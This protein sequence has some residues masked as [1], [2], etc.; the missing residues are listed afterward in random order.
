ML[1]NEN[2]DVSEVV[3]KRFSI[4]MPFHN[5][6]SYLADSI[7]SIVNQKLDF[8]E[9]VQLI[10]V[11]CGSDDESSAIAGEYERQYPENIFLITL[12]SQRI[13]EGNNAGFKYAKGDYVTFMGGS[14]K[15]HEDS[16]TQI[17]AA[18]KKYNEDIIA[19]PVSVFSNENHT[20]RLYS[21]KGIIDL[22]EF[23]EKN[24]KFTYSVF[25]RK[26]LVDDL[27][28]DSRIV[29]SYDLSYI[30]KALLK[31][32]K[33]VLLDTNAYYF[34]KKRNS[35]DQEL[36]NYAEFYLSEIRYFLLEMMEYATERYGKVEDFAKMQVLKKFAF[37]YKNNQFNEV[38]SKEQIEEFFDS[39]KK[40]LS[41][42][43]ND[44]I[45]ELIDDQSNSSFVIAVKNGDITPDN[46]IN[47]DRSDIFNVEITKNNVCVYSKDDIIDNV[48]ERAIFLDF[49]TLR[50]DVLYFSGFLRTILN[51][52]NISVVGI[53][54]YANGEV[55]IIDATFYDYPTRSSSFMMGLEWAST[56]NF[57]LA[58]PIK[59]KKEVSSVKI[60]AYYTENGKKAK[61]EC[62]IEFRMYCNISYL[63]H[64]YV[65]DDRIIMFNGK[66][67]IMPY[68]YRK[69]VR[70]E[71]RGLIKVF[72]E[73]ELFYQQALFF[74]VC[75]ML[76]YPFM[77]NKEIWMIMDRKQA[78]DD[79]AEH[80]F[81]Y[82][83]Q[84]D[85]GIKKFFSINESSPDYERL[86]ETYGNVL[87]FESIKHRF[88]YTFTDKI[89]SSQGSEFY[90][91]P[92]RHR[93]FYQTAGI[94]NL[95][96]YFLQHGIIKDNMSSWLRKY[97]RNPKLIVTSTQ[98]EYESLFDE[99]YNYGDNVIQL[100]GLPRY[101]NLNNKGLKKQ[102]VI[103][104]SW[105]NFLTDEKMVL[106]SE[107]FK[108]FN[109][110]INNERFINHA[111]EKG[112]EIVFKPHPELVKYLHLFDKNDYVQIDEHKKYQVIF[113]ESALLITDYSSIFFDFSYLKKPLIY[114]QYGNDYHYDSENG[115]FQYDTMGFGPVIDNEEDLVDKLIEYMDNDCVMEDMY[116]ERVDSFFKYND[117]NNS[118]R[119]YDWIHS[120]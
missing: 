113:N 97:D 19:L 93:R 90:L 66:F 7:E 42:F 33:Y 5:N 99:G 120:H 54:E 41:Y 43:S 91:N 57:D 101:D 55:E 100:L 32:N 83:L 16:L 71:L 95:D 36:F 28:F 26:S 96:F 107:Y 9:N 105:R 46:V 53:K 68:S 3:S 59:S 81:K 70:Y 86:Q 74:R 12:D 108:H 21:N 72:K 87:A 17:L 11:D 4:V 25:F 20:P 103:M 84:Q 24:L 61:L 64:Y 23:P 31:T 40:T 89:I 14:D 106:K 34:Y 48:S 112:Y 63:S 94:S 73:R 76:L 39:M 47:N 44:E 27:S 15:L 18:F 38:L 45:T 104:P 80:F 56:Y 58:V 62:S 82:A 37:L 92:F 102:I 117:H 51:R 52:E 115:Y 116:K 6:E 49:A 2:Y 85:D 22:D 79:N 10:L 77:K 29:Y 109:S 50:D 13:V 110:L 35:F 119:C 78:A 114:Y 1:V 88:Y 75:H 30:T 118:K 111:K 69:M 98:L 8:A 67:N 65:K 60:V